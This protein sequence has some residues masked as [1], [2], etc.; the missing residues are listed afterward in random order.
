MSGTIDF[1][2]FQELDARVGVI[3]QV[4]EA[5]GCRVPAW[6]LTIDFGAE[7]GTRR[8]IAEAR[9]YRREEL[10]GKQ[11]LAV[12]NLKPR[13]VGRHVSEVPTL[14]VPT[15]GRGTALIVPAGTGAV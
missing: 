4:D 6:R 9:N 1:S 13:Q 11:V 15:E 3:V 8:S 12:G 14:G 5:E 7:L 2:A 10:L